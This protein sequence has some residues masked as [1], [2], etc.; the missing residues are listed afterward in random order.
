MT[1]TSSKDIQV[2]F[3]DEIRWKV[4]LQSRISKVLLVKAYYTK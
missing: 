4:D 1:F 2:L 3:A